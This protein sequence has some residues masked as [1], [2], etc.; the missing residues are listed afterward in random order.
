MYVRFHSRESRK[1]FEPVKT[2]LDMWVMLIEIDFASKIDSNLNLGFVAFDA[3][4]NIYTQVHCAI[5]FY[6]TISK[7]K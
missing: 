5:Y 7:H 6:M 2:D 1:W 3:K 4:N